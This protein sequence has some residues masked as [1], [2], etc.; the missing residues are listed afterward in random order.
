[1]LIT[2]VQRYPNLEVLRQDLL[3]GRVT[4]RVRFAHS[5][6]DKD[7]PAQYKDVADRAYEL[8]RALAKIFEHEND[9]TSLMHTE[10]G[11]NACHQAKRN[12]SLK[13]YNRLSAATKALSKIIDNRDTKCPQRHLTW[14]NLDSCCE[15]R[16]EVLIRTMVTACDQHHLPGWRTVH[17]TMS[18]NNSF[19][20]QDPGWTLCKTLWIT[21]SQ[22]KAVHIE[23]SPDG[24]WKHVSQKKGSSI[25]LQSQR[26]EDI[27]WAPE[28]C[29]PVHMSLADASR[30]KKEERLAFAVR[31]LQSVLCLVGSPLVERRWK[32]EDILVPRRTTADDGKHSHQLYLGERPRAMQ[33]TSTRSSACVSPVFLVYSLGLLA[34]WIWHLM[35]VSLQYQYTLTIDFH[36]FLNSTFNGSGSLDGRSRSANPLTKAYLSEADAQS[37]SSYTTPI[38][39]P[40]MKHQLVL[41]LILTLFQ[42]LFLKKV[43]ITIEDQELGLGG[44]LQHERSLFNALRREADTYLYEHLAKDAYMTLIET[45]LDLY[46]ELGTMDDMN[47]RYTIHDMIFTPL[48]ALMVDNGASKTFK[49]ETNIAT[50]V[51]REHLGSE[52]A[53]VWFK[54]LEQCLGNRVAVLRDGDDER[55]K[56]AVLDTGLD[57]NHTVFKE[58]L[59]LHGSKVWC[60][61]DWTK[62]PSATEDEQQDASINKPTDDKVGHGTAVCDILVRVSKVQL[63]VGKISD[64]AL[65]SKDAPA[66]VA[67]AIEYAARTWQVH[68]IVMSLGFEK[69]DEEIR[70]AVKI[71]TATDIIIFAA[72]SNS[73]SH[74]PDKRVAF[75][76][77][78]SGH[79]LSI[80][81]ATAQRKL[82]DASPVPRAGE[83]NFAV[84]GE[85]ITA[86]DIRTEGIAYF[87]GSSFATP[88]AAGIAA[89]ML[90]FSKHRHRIPL[91]ERGSSDEKY[92]VP[93]KPEIQRILRSYEGI[94]R[95]FRY[96]STVNDLAVTE[97]F[98]Y[99]SPWTLFAEGRENE[100]LWKELCHQM[101]NN[102]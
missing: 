52:R 10:G 50:R 69:S 94:R 93:V 14:V 86:A 79:V 91:K 3:Q 30:H 40:T 38:H 42:L 41:D 75:P 9:E 44:D 12:F 33:R 15:S 13:R 73:G 39:V 32:P 63:Y 90:E 46:Q 8:N 16:D 2:T 64:T 6:K 96:M 51:S 47:F 48:E 43:E 11:N 45:C 67:R 68:I 20:E 26:I 84:L 66:T 27:S 81:S 78:L 85:A 92:A 49:N 58:S 101:M 88:V 65:F 87:S 34:G 29:Y 60:R 56:V 98:A 76:A 28:D 61:R 100:W 53:T 5:K 95:M 71:A 24:S 55:V 7:V 23:L 72:A 4:V 22:Q 1:M 89:L 59:K 74:V 18:Q 25:K 21:S 97:G 54:D 36:G 19:Q 37:T 17:W 102:L 77:R 99:I 70:K 62:L 80:R 31:V 57:E 35:G 83:D 82:A